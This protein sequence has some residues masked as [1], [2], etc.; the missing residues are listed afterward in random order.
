M[1]HVGTRAAKRPLSP[2]SHAHTH[3]HTQQNCGRAT[4]A[5]WLAR[6][7]RIATGFADGGRRG[8]REQDLLVSAT[9]THSCN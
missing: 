8:S 1:E 7:L 6:M 2:S 9:Y 5:K 4:L 3:T